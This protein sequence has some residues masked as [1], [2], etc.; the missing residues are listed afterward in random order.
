MLEHQVTITSY[1][2]HFL[3]ITFLTFYVLQYL[4]I[5][6]CMNRLGVYPRVYVTNG[7][8]VSEYKVKHAALTG[9]LVCNYEKYCIFTSPG[10]G[11]V[12]HHQC[13]EKLRHD[14]RAV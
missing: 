5:K 9:K 13:H 1:R 4:K 14:S 10:V 8:A 2:K 3:K 6:T 7:F 11:D 12:K